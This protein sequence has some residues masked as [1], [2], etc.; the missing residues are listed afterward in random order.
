MP[1]LFTSVSMRPHAAITPSTMRAMLA[2]S[3][4]SMWNA[5]AVPPLST[6]AFAT[7]SASP[8]LMS[9]TATF[10]PSR[11]NL[12]AVASPMP[13][14]EPVMIATLSDQTHG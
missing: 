9:Q 6:I 14:A 4:T 13:E 10:A 5:S 8:T 7:R 3:V 2:L 1:A 11:A 12:I